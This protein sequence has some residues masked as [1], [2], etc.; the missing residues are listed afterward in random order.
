MESLCTTVII[1]LGAVSSIT[2]DANASDIH[3]LP[4]TEVEPGIPLELP[5]KATESRKRDAADKPSASKKVK[6]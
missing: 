1:D 3:A 6:L 2:D 5:V 4:T